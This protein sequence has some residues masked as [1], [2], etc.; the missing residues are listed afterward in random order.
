MKHFS[1]TLFFLA[2]LF[3]T[4]LLFA[5]DK[6]PL[7]TSELTVISHDGNEL[8]IYRYPAKG[9][10]LV[11]WIGGSGWND[12]T[13]QLARDFAYKGIEVWQIDFADALL[14]T[15]SSN[16]L[17]NLDASYVA[18]IIDAAHQRTGKNV[19]LFTQAYG[20]IPLLRGAT[21]WQQRNKHKGKLLGAIIFSPDLLTG[22]PALGKDPE[23]LPIAR[24]TD[25]PMIIFQGGLRGSTAHFLGFLNVLTSH[26]PHIYFKMM[27]DI[28][29]VFYHEEPNAATYAMLKT[30]PDKM[31]DMIN[32]LA[33][34]PYPYTSKY[35]QPG[36]QAIATLDSSLKTFKGNP[37]PPAIDL[38]DSKG[39]VYKIKDYHGKVT[40]VN[41]WA[42]WCPPCVAEI[43]SLNRLR[44]Q[45]Q[46]LDFEL[47]SVNYADTSK[48]VDE[49][50]QRVDVKFPVLLDLQ[51]KVAQQWNVIGFP[52]TFVIGKDGKILYGVNAAIHWDDADVIKTLKDLSR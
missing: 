16:F 9:K 31:H 20:A 7:P 47:V 18:D 40:V 12:R 42:T 14:Q 44:E 17:R 50:M 29:G 48:V 37:L 22:L 21:L 43:P 23:Y 2:L 45:M 28:A 46:G 39:H 51:G 15:S 32:L 13:T 3:S 52:S 24:A 33:V 34:T 19:V 5:E 10:N 30:L 1:L 49:F 36:Q 35:V 41:F 6:L 25:I 4:P 26:N 27:P 38:K 8:P 11:L